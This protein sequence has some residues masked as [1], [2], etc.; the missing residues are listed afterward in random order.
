[1][2]ALLARSP[3]TET[4]VVGDGFAVASGQ[5]DNSRNGV[6]CSRLPVAS[7][8]REITA[9]LSWLGE[10][11]VRAQWLVAG[12]TE[13][14]DLGERLQR[15]GCEPERAVVQ[16]AERL[17]ALDLSPR[18]LPSGLEIR[19]IADDASLAQGLDD[20]DDTRL[21]AALG[22][23]D[24]APVRHYAALLSARTVGVTSVLIDGT[25]LEVFAL[26]VS[27]SERRRGVGRALLLHALRE[28]RAA[29]V[30]AGH[31]GAHPGERPVLR[32]TRSHARALSARPSV[33]HAA[34]V[35]RA[36]T[37]GRSTAEA[38]S[39]AAL[40]RAVDARARSFAETIDAFLVVSVGHRV[41]RAARI[42]AQSP[43]SPI[44]ALPRRWSS[45]M[46]AGCAR[47]SH[48]IR[49]SCRATMSRG[50]GLPCTSSA[51]LAGTLTLPAHQA[52]SRS[53]G[54]CSTAAPIRTSGPRGR[55]ASGRCVARSSAQPR[56]STTGRSSSCCSS[57]V[58]APMTTSSTTRDSPPTRLRAD[59]C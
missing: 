29:G 56:V 43:G 37:Q 15:A 24:T 31:P 19:P 21:L 48:A 40:T 38:S 18:P 41:G 47:S 5:R 10:R 57:V 9:V 36:Q 11:E 30:H 26:E 13:P 27:R 2:L 45:A 17:V 8:D 1:M 59:H 42:L 33:L 4:R 49:G 52:C 20:R 51:R 12:E 28:G 16:M 3:L 39:A 22:L 50:V 32:G 35:I 54:Y 55:G 7:A 6:V 46:S 44:T 34:A 53:P 23:D 25:T 58:R 14:A